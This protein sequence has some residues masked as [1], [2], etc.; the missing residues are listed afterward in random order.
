VAASAAEAGGAAVISPSA[1][2]PAA[3]SLNVE[4]G[5]ATPKPA[6]ERIVG[7]SAFT[8]IVSGA[9]ETAAA[10]IGAAG[11][12][13]SDRSVL[14]ERAADHRQGSLV[15][16]SSAESRRTAPAAAARSAQSHEVREGQI[17]QG[18]VAGRRHL[19]EPKG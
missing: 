19:E 17:L 2:E 5:S 6:I 10:T 12:R 16:D 18:Q 7:K 8:R 13:A 9:A 3:V 11:A 14:H 4:V 15:V 1:A